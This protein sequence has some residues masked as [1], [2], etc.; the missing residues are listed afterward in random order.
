MQRIPALTTCCLALALLGAVTPA[1]D[2]LERTPERVTATR[3]PR[4]DDG[5]G[6]F[7]AAS[8]DGRRV[9]AYGPLSQPQTAGNDGTF[10]IYETYKGRTT[11][12]SVGSLG[13][14][15]Y[16]SFSA[17]S[18]DGRVVIWESKSEITPG[19]ADG[20]GQDV[21]FRANGRTTEISRP[22][23]GGHKTNDES[24]IRA[25]Y[26]GTSQDGRRIFF[27]S[28]ERLTSADHDDLTDLYEYS[29]GHP[30][31]LT[32]A[33]TGPPSSIAF[34]GA[35]DDGSRVFFVA[36]ERLAAGDTDDSQD[37]YERTAGH[38]VLVTTGHGPYDLE[39]AYLTRHYGYID[40][41]P[42]GRHVVFA[43]AERL[44]PDDTDDGID[45]YEWSNGQTTRISTGSR[46][47]NGPFDAITT[48]RNTAFFWGL[49]DNGR[50][51]VFTTEEALTNDDNDK[52]GD[53]YQR[54]DGTT[55]QL[56]AAPAAGQVAPT[57][58]YSGAVGSRDGRR[59][60]FLSYDRVTKDDH[61][62]RLD[63]FE[64]FD[65]RVR[66]ISRGPVG[67]NANDVPGEFTEKCTREAEAV[68]FGTFPN[69]S[70]LYFTTRER[71][72]A[73]DSDGRCSSYESVG[74]RLSLMT[75][76]VRGRSR[77]LGLLPSGT[78][79]DGRTIYTQTEERWVR[80]DTDRKVDVY[81][82]RLFS[83]PRARLPRSN[84][85][86]DDRGGV[87]V[88]LRCPRGNDPCRGRATLTVRS[89]RALASASFDVGVGHSRSTRLKLSPSAQ[90]TVRH[91]SLGVTLIAIVN[92]EKTRLGRLVLAA[93]R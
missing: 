49:S 62:H 2:A 71:L 48:Y 3:S 34:A 23:D 33:G 60:Y 75:F 52:L 20:G 57:G 6:P 83:V 91:R 63:I 76:R 66:R 36:S 58:G 19:D 27:T 21:F 86:V 37:L 65:G 16:P 89:G 38:T 50:R 15:V 64:S 68:Y 70:R 45:L 55:R 40:L 61:D 28:A 26:E 78:S 25:G 8:T 82:L 77:P 85:T 14:G 93:G 18:A 1:A 47:G 69:V 4:G 46:G 90:R 30:T 10:G 88:S 5:F 29:N 7:L 81:A 35:S 39:Q 22:P 51:T 80:G 53:V 92:G 9:F 67:G 59:V 74:G 11:L 24:S 43:T 17:I 56:S 13:A 12:Q 79:P 87:G 44:T 54:T 32:P 73:S 72:L 31:L 42:D 41:T 84:A